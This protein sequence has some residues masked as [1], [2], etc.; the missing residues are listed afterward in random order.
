MLGVG[1]HRITINGVAHWVRVAGNDGGSPIVVVHGGPGA[2]A[3][4]C[5]QTVGPRL[6]E[7]ATVVYYDQR[8]CGRSDAP[9][10]PYTYSMD[11]L[12]ADLD[13]LRAELGVA[14]IS[15]L[16]QSFGGRIAAAYAVAHPDR[17]DRLMLHAAP[18][19]NPLRPNA[20]SLRPALVDAVL[21]PAARAAMRAELAGLSGQG[22]RF[23]AAHRALDSDPVATARFLC[24]D[25]ARAPELLRLLDAAEALGTNEKMGPAL[26]LT[27]ADELFDQLAEVDV[28]TMVM[29]GLTDR[30]VGVDA[31]R[32]LA[33]RLPRGALHLFQRSAH[34]PEVEEP[35]S[36]AEAVRAFLGR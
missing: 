12:V 19:T 29:V 28:P 27:G 15:P 4:L 23:D 34:F 35:D 1:E 13:V 14:R 25:P 10:E 33:G 7:F 26:R 24:H 20:W 22:E 36:Y 2:N 6:A 8:G 18:I 21:G 9:A 32:D 30:N 17:V 3:S 11:Q 31:C 16:G 5:E